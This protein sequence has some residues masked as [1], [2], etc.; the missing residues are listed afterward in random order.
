MATGAVSVQATTILVK[1]PLIRPRPRVILLLLLI[2]KPPQLWMRACK[3]VR[4]KPNLK[5]GVNRATS[6]RIVP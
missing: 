2:F 5:A 1:T 6:L 3:V 4:S